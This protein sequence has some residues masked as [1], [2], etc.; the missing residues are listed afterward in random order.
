MSS[1]FLGALLCALV[2]AQAHAQ[3]SE[4]AADAN[5]VLATQGGQQVTMADI[6]QAVQEVPIERRDHF[7]DSP[8]RI[9]VLISGLLLQKQL[10]AQA[11]AAGLD[12]DPK[13]VAASGIAQIKLL[14]V[15]QSEHFR[16]TIKVPDLTTLARE[17]YV[18][19]REKYIVPAK[20]E[21][22]DVLITTGARS[23]AEA[24]ALADKIALEARSDPAQFD[25][26]VEKYSGQAD[27]AMTKGVV[28]DPDNATNGD[29][30]VAAANA[31]A[32]PGDISAVFKTG[33][34]FHV[35]K[36]V[37]KSPARQQTFDEVREAMLSLLGEEYSRKSIQDYVDGMRNQPM[38]ANAELIASLR[39]RYAGTAT[40]AAAGV[41]SGK[42]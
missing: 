22:Q 38:Q 16:D 14:A 32:A 23:D 26:L 24:K 28:R 40:P 1:R 17:R 13:I 33:D 25:A 15:A 36:L 42:S 34:G 7:I 35:L 6:D 12:K 37:A 39:T 41:S 2:C 19:N 4:P 29:A 9:E 10:A 31:L 20:L 11:R 18:A 8:K 5:A 3:M 21:V 27:K 30:F